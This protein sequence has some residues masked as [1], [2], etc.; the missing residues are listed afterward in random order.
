MH[1]PLDETPSASWL[2]LIRLGTILLGSVLVANVAL[3]AWALSPETG[4]LAAVP[5]AGEQTPPMQS[6]DERLSG[7]SD[8]TAGSNS[9]AV[10]P[11]PAA[12]PATEVEG[13]LPEQEADPC[14]G[15]T[16]VNPPMSGGVVHFVV[17]GV[18]CSLQPGE[19]QQLA[20]LGQRRI[21]FH[22]G[23]DFGDADY[24]LCSGAFLFQVEEDGWELWPTEDSDAHRLLQICREA[25]GK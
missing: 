12:A 7:G 11:P 21:Q 1:E 23:D 16:L 8:E 22:R 5:A 15:L 18:V 13:P 17:D 19:Y 2:P 14:R 20:A 10:E 6:G 4:P 25:P 3:V 9:G 24:R